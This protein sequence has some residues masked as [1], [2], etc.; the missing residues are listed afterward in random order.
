[1]ATSAAIPLAFADPTAA[2]FGFT[3]TLLAP[4]N[5]PPVFTSTPVTQA[6][7]GAA[8]SYQ[9]TA[10]DPDGDPLTYQLLV[11][12]AG[13]SIGPQSGLVQWT[14][15]LDQLGTQDVTLQVSDGRGGSATQTFTVHFPAPPPP[16]NAA[17]LIVST[18][19]YTTVSSGQPFTYPA[20]ALDPD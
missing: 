19:P 20:R 4:A 11:G 3:T 9:A 2:R 14:P 15:T 10:A 16:S 18:P 13:M 8:Y 12:P 7:V 1:G 5:H 6:S 17:P